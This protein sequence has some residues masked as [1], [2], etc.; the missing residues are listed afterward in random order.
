MNSK[1]NAPAATSRVS[2]ELRRF[3]RAHRL[4]GP[5]ALVAFSGG[6]DSMALLAALS[7]LSS[8]L[9]IELG[10]CWVDHGIRP[11]GELA[12]ER[13]FVQ[14]ACGR[15]GMAL[16]IR[17][18]PRGRIAAR[19]GDTGT[20]DA[21]RRERYAALEDE[22]RAGAWDAILTA[23]TAD[24]MAETMVM[25]FFSGS[26]AAGL[27]GIPAVRDRLFRP[28]LAVGKAELLA[29]LA[30]RGLGYRV[31]STNE[32]DEYLRNRVRHEL[33]PAIARVFPG[34]R[35]ALDALAAKARADEDALAS[36][37]YRLVSPSGPGVGI[38]IGLFLAAPVAVRERALYILADAVP[39]QEEG[40][41]LSWR[42]VSQAASA[43]Q[44]PGRA[45]IL[46]SGAGLEVV[47]DGANVRV[48]ARREAN[49][50]YATG[51]SFI[52]YGAGIYRIAKDCSF[53]VYYAGTGLRTDAFSWPIVVRGRRPG[54]EIRCSGGTKR[55][56]VALAELGVPAV[57][58]DT[59]PV[60]EDRDGLVAILASAEGCRDLYRRNDGLLETK[61]SRHIAIMRKGLD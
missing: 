44:R 34:Y 27:R 30:E 16:A 39:G 26:A 55:L 4:P 10:A 37:A 6:P 60:V 36:A 52:A 46:A 42:L 1:K 15:L 47:S 56:D 14:E 25:R 33:L 9:G 3:F 54:D 35:K 17:E 32:T 53:E 8:E 5:R 28:F 51:F 49:S 43:K 31:D 40:R 18:I 24:D 20:E 7:E 61:A 29:W 23:H 21:A 13:R 59:V 41:R 22:R 58:R 50:P 45:A 38:E 48:R 57:R 19:A 2:S 11:E 12:G